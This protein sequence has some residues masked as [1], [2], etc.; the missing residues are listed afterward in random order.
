MQVEVL[1]SMQIVRD[2]RAVVGVAKEHTAF[3]SRNKQV[4]CLTLDLNV[5]TL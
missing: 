1:I 3:V 4:T 5:K 2:R